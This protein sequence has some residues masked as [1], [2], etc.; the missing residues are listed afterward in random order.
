MLMVVASYAMA[1]DWMWM[2]YI[3]SRQVSWLFLVYVLISLYGLPLIA[4]LFLGQELYARRKIYWL[5]AI[6]A[7]LLVEGLLL[8]L[9]WDRY[10]FISDY[11][12]FLQRKGQPLVGSTHPLALLLNMGGVILLVV[13]V[14]LWRRLKKLYASLN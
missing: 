6:L 3:D 7:C 4:G 2:Y 9:L 8:A 10:N 13:A 11:L 5:A 14:Y 1:P 12:G